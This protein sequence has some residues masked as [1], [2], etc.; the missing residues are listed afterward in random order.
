[1]NKIRF[2]ISL[3]FFIS[4][5]TL[6][7]QE[8]KLINGQFSGIR[9]PQLVRE[10]ETQT[11]WHIYYDSLETDSLEIN[12]TANQISLQQLFGIVFKN[13]NIHF[14]FGTGNDVFVTKQ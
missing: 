1:M 3:V 13:T 14:A 2:Y 8:R 10:I 11:S 9:F 5:F 6:K 7:A 12:V 4:C